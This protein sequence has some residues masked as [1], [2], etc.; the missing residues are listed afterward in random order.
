METALTKPEKGI[1]T[2]KVLFNQDNIKKKFE[3]LLGKKA[4]GFITSVLQIVASNDLLAKSDAMSVYNAAAVAAVLDLPLNNNLGFAYI[5]PYNQ[6]QKDNTWKSV[7]Q[8][9][10][11]YKGFIQLAQRSGQFKTISAAPIY[12]G[13]LV[14]ENP[15]TGFVFDFTKKKSEVIIG[16][17]AY[18]SLINGF[19][20][21]LFLKAE[22]M[23]NHGLKY[24]QTYKKGFGLWA[25]NFESMAIKTVLKLLLSKF[26]PLSIE[27]QKA[28]IMD[29][30][31]IN[32]HVT[33]DIT[34]A[35]N[36]DT[37]IDKAAERVTIM[38]GDAKT[39]KDLEKLGEKCDMTPEQIELFEAKKEELKHGR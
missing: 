19:E 9:Q 6:K 39:V 22:E 23:K 38:I 8:F 2:A 37:V 30:A 10:M 3:E 34:Y 32:D 17:A 4:Q 5:V 7:A 15:L 16:Y 27:M 18:F 11:G 36:E 12:E 35:D 13:Q 20:K 14:E 21:T 28:T 33:E 31:I 25:D 26:A 1:M 24:S 29:Q